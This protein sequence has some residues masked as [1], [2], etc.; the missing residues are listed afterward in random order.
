MESMEEWNDVTSPRLFLVVLA[1][2]APENIRPSDSM[3]L[4][5]VG[6]LDSYSNYIL[7]AY[8]NSSHLRRPGTL[9]TLNSQ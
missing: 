3:R 9:M 5:V 2:K 7:A 1:S 6:L 8:P 4:D